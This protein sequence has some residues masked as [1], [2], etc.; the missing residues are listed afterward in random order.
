MDRGMRPRRVAVMQP[1]FFPYVGTYQLAAAVDEFVFLDDAAF[2]K[3]SYLNR[4]SIL[5]DGA[6]HRFSVPVAQASQNRAINAHS[7]TGDWSPLKRLLHNAYGRAPQASRVLPLIDTVLDDPDENLARKNARSMQA[8]FEYL[9]G[10]P[11]WTLASQRPS[12]DPA[13]RG[14]SR[15]LHLCQAHGAEVYV[16]PPGGRALYDA[17]RFAEQGVQ[18]RFLAPQALPYVQAAPAFVPWLSIIDLLMHLPP[19]EVRERLATYTLTD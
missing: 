3:K 5:L 10:G 15:I 18:L 7:F 17:A 2:M 1:Y 4:N 14:Q 9:G 11:R 19:D 16:N 13:C 12:P 6:A 8:V